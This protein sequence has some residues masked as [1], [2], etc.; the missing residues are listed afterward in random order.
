MMIKTHFIPKNWVTKPPAIG[1]MT[2]PGKIRRMT[3]RKVIIYIPKRGPREYNAMAV[4]LS[5]SENKSLIDPPPTAIG[6]LPDIPATFRCL[7]RIRKKR[8]MKIYI[9][10][11]TYTGNEVLSKPLSLVQM[12]IP[13]L[14][15]RSWDC[16]YGGPGKDDIKQGLKRIKRC[17]PKF[18]HTFPTEGP[19]KGAVKH[20]SSRRGW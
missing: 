20:V 17:L 8:R 13:D 19:E 3:S 10:I 16:R 12:H 7:F 5:R 15:L 6:A 4:A 9:Y 11:F 14:Y 1:P 2:G 18:A